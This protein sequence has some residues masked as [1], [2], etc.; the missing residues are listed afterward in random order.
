MIYVGLP[1]TPSRQQILEIG[2]K[3][4]NFSD[5][6]D[7]PLLANEKYTGGF[8]GAEMISICREA[9]LYAI[10]EEDTNDFGIDT[11]DMES[12]RL[13]L[14]NLSLSPT[15]LSSPRQAQQAIKRKQKINA[16]RFSSSTPTNHPVPKLS[17]SPD[18]IK[19]NN[20][21]GPQICM[22]HLLRA[23]EGTKRQITPEMLDFYASFQNRSTAQ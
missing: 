14:K 12:A 5:D 1:D 6:V 7:I 20:T 10:E 17:P 9:A 18:G 21:T 4:K 2:L 3:G 16:A 11:T 8:S 23:I 13:Q 19:S 15:Y 22:R